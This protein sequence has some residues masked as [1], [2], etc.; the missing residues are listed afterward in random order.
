MTSL[1]LTMY[2][3]FY[4]AVVLIVIVYIVN[5]TP[6]FF[7]FISKNDRHYLMYHLPTL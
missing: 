2:Q 4:I 6:N 7:A 3:T 1:V 5:I